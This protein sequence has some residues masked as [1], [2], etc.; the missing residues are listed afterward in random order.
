MSKIKVLIV[1][2]ELII[3]EDMRE[4]LEAIGYEVPYI[5][6]N[7]REAIEAIKKYQPDLIMLDIMMGGK[8][9]GIELARYIRANHDLPFVFCT[10]H[11]DKATVEEAKATKPNGYLVKPF[12][13]EELYTSIE[14]A[15]VNYSKAVPAVEGTKSTDL[16]V[17]DGMFVKNG[18]MYVK[19]KFEHMLWL[20]PDG[21]YTSIVT[22][23]SKYIVRSTLKDILDHLPDNTFFRIHRSYV[24]NLDH[25]QAIDL[26]QVKI[27]D[28]IIPLGKAYRDELILRL[29]LMQ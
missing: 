4:I 1:E 16:L 14:I 18:Q 7:S 20:E 23:A 19:V 25:V 15:L 8:P 22:A 3:A 21:N 10:S 17:K 12:N 13:S 5:A 24:I 28:Q 2:D 26:H 27:A 29:N 9:A 11:A 6:M